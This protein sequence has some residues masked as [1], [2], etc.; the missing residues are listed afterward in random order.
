M[1]QTVKVLISPPLLADVLRLPEGSEVVSAGMSAD[2]VYVTLT[3]AHPAFADAVEEPT[4]VPH[5]ERSATE[6]E[7][8]VIFIDWGITW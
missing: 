3:V 8:K 5:Y 6:T 4:A 1:S 7:P 2:G